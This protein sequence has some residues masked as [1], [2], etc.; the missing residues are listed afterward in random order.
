MS[1]VLAFGDEHHPFSHRD[2]LDFIKEVKDK[3]N[4]DT[5]VNLGDEIDAHAFSRYVHDPSGYGPQHEWDKAVKALKP[6][7]ELFPKLHICKSNHPM[8]P[9]RRAFDVGIPGSFFKSY[10]DLIDA[11]EG[12]VWAGFFE[13]DGVRYIHGEGY[14]GELGHKK[15]A[16]DYGKSVVMGHLHTNFGVYT[17]CRGVGNTNPIYGV[18]AGC[19]T[20]TSSYACAYAKNYSKQPILGAVVLQD[21][22]PKMIPMLFKSGKK[23]DRWTGVI[24]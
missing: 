11:P 20:D 17:S 13:F 5:V 9:F 2:R 23:S 8:R 12:W 1:T 16:E 22:I 15:A 7:Y 3:Y 10:T 18:A 21:G 19:G 4:P 6:Y 14:N 24:V